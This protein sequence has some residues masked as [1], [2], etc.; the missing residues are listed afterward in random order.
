MSE[1]SI[2]PQFRLWVSGTCQRIRELET[3]LQQTRR[4]LVE[5]RLEYTRLAQT[6]AQI[7]SYMHTFQGQPLVTEPEERASDAAQ[8]PGL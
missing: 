1:K 5:A 4:E 6:T 7:M 2:P 3:Q 8:V